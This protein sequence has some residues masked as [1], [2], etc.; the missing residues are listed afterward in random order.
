MYQS[1]LRRTLNVPIRFWLF[2]SKQEKKMKKLNSSICVSPSFRAKWGYLTRSENR[3]TMSTPQSLSCKFVKQARVWKSFPSS[4]LSLSPSIPQRSG[5]R[6]HDTRNGGCPLLGGVLL[7]RDDASDCSIYLL[8]ADVTW[9]GWLDKFCVLCWST[10]LSIGKWSQGFAVSTSDYW[11]EEFQL[12]HLQF[13]IVEDSERV[14]HTRYLSDTFTFSTINEFS[15]NIL[16]LL[17]STFICNTRRFF[18]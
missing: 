11:R 4:V 15:I 12:R 7:T 1:D 13:I 14:S 5:K 8:Y 3:S 9:G 10:D 17:L 6:I 2:Q 16:L 18:P